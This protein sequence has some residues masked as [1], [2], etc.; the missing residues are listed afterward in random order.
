MGQRGRAANIDQAMEKLDDE[1]YLLDMRMFNFLFPDC[2]IIRERF[3]LLTKSMV[4]LRA[5]PDNI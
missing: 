2:R 1:P 4:A 5:A 3:C